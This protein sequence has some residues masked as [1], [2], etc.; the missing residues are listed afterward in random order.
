VGLGEKVLLAVPYENTLVPTHSPDGATFD[1]AVTESLQPHVWVCGVDLHER[2]TMRGVFLHVLGDAI[3]S[4]N[5]IISAL[6]IKFLD[7]DTRWKYY[8]DPTARQ[9]AI[10]SYRINVCIL[11]IHVSVF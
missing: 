6:L 8:I 2:M 4:V 11:A 10:S 3:S 7:D 5:V 1:A 9:Q